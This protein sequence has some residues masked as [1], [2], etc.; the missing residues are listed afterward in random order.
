MEQSLISIIFATLN[1]EKYIGRTLSILKKVLDSCGVSAE[2]IVVDSSDNDLT[3]QIASCFTDKVFRFSEKGLAK[4]RN[5]GA[6]KAHGDILV[7]MDADSIPQ[8]CIFKD[9]L[10]ALKEK[11]VVAAVTYVQTYD[12]KLTLA[13]KIF[14]AIDITF[15]KACKTIPFLLKFYN[16]GDFLAVKRDVFDKAGRF[17]EKLSLMEITNFIVRVQR[18]GKVAVLNKPVYESS[19]RLKSWGSLKS[20]LYWWKNYASYYLLKKPLKKVYPIIR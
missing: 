11:G 10:E 12:K 5:Y 6:S 2:I 14:Y 18:I 15:I 16:R 13:Q 19:R 7:Y 3:S 4:A 17:D 8:V 20:H 9:L 1:E